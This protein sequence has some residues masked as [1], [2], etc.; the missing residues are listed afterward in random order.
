MN[1]VRKRDGFTIVELLI[2]IVVIGILAAI[3]VVAYGS[4]QGKAK[5][6]KVNTELVAMRKAIELYKVD[7]GT[8]PP[9]AGSF[10]YQRVDGNN[11]IPGIVPTYASELPSVTDTPYGGN[12]N[13]TYIYSSNATATGYTVQRLY[14]TEVPAS[15]WVN[16]PTAQKQ[17]AYLDR[18]GYG[19][20]L[21]G[22]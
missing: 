14:Q 22:Y 20:N 3:T 19:Y 11:F 7:N 17:G 4:I 15:E 9:T 1:L 12:T 2:V 6:N 16:V 8:Y 13:D 18:Y 5:Y 10:R 21:A